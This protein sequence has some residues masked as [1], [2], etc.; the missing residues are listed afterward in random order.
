MNR[1]WVRGEPRVTSV[2]RRVSVDGLDPPLAVD[3]LVGL[4]VVAEAVQPSGPS[5][6]RSMSS[7]AQTPVAVVGE[8]I[9][10]SG[11]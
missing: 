7:I 10:I 11:M 9:S 5:G 3:L 8:V 2:R 4:V 6:Q 1:E